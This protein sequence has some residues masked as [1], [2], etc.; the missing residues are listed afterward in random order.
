MSTSH[1]NGPAN[2]NNVVDINIVC[3]LDGKFRKFDKWLYST[4]ILTMKS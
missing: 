3:M 4:V 2:S 1:G